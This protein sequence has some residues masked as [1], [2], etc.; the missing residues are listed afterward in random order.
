MKRALI[1][2][3]SALGVRHGRRTSSPNETSLNVGKEI[4]IT[5][6]DALRPARNVDSRNIVET[7]SEVV[8]RMSD[9]YSRDAL[10]GDTDRK[11]DETL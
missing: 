1:K 11:G 8:T 9:A 4:N 6:L 7:A 2:G 10:D 5:G 3:L